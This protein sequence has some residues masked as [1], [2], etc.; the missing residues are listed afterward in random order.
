MFICVFLRGEGGDAVDVYS[1]QCAIAHLGC[2]LLPARRRRRQ[3]VRKSPAAV[4]RGVI[5]V[6]ATKKVVGYV[7]YEKVLKHLYATHS[8]FVDAYAI[9]D[10]FC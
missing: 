9:L 10:G 1:P 4:V 8:K 5:Y 6:H 2:A 3:R 7:C